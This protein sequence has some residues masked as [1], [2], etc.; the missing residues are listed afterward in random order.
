MQPQEREFKIFVEDTDSSER[1]AATLF[2]RS[3]GHALRIFKSTNKKI[4]VTA[5]VGLASKRGQ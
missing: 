1:L 2:A 4:H 3:K 5:V